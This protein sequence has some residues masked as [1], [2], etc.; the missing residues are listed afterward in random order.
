M[1]TGQSYDYRWT[2]T[3][4]RTILNV[5]KWANISADGQSFS[6]SVNKYLKKV[7]E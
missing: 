5:N 4:Y 1:G 3:V 7:P 2:K 6:V